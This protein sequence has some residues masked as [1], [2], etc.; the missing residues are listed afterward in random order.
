MKSCCLKCR[1]DTENINP[2][3]SNTRNSRTM[4]LSKSAICDSKRSRFLKNQEGKELLS[5]LSVR[6]C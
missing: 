2:R 1:K 4:T 6:R 5:I 3:V